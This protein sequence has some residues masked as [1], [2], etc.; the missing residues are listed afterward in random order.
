MTNSS[1]QGQ[2]VALCDRVEM[3]SLRARR[4]SDRAAAQLATVIP[5]TS[6]VTLNGL[7]HFGPDQT[8]PA[9]VAQAITDFFGT[10][11]S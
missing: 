9:Q 2:P 4:S 1:R 7:D 5:H 10:T 11:P 8:G 3:N 6:R